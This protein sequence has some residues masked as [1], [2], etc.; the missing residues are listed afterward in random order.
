M[1][2]SF[3]ACCYVFAKEM[4]NGDSFQMSENLSTTNKRKESKV[5]TLMSVLA[6]NCSFGK[7]KPRVKGAGN[8][9]RN[10]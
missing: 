10:Q 9:E 5:K 8:D 3:R 7:S 6:A 2:K 4:N 1:P